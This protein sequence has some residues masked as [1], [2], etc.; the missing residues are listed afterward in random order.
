MKIRNKIILYFSSTTIV[1]CAIT[2]FVIYQLVAAYRENLFQDQLKDKIVFSLKFLEEVQ[3]SSI[4]LLTNLDQ[5]TINDLYEEKL[6]LFDSNKKLIY[7]SLDDTKILKAESILK[8]LNADKKWIETKEGDFDVIGVRVEIKGNEFYGI[9]KAYDTFGHL[10]LNYLKYT[11]LGTFIVI[12]L[13]TLLISSYLSQ[14]IF[15]PIYRMTME[16]EAIDLNNKNAT[17][18]IENETDEFGFLAQKFNELIQKLQQAFT[19]QK[20]TIHHI[21]HELKTP[22]AILVSNLE[23]MEKE[24]DISTLQTLITAQ[25]ENTLSLGGIINTLLE[26]SKIESGTEMPFE[27]LRIDELLMDVA[28]EIQKLYSDFSM[29]VSFENSIVNESDLRIKG[30]LKLLTIGIQNMISNSIKY[31]SNQKAE[32]SIGG[33][34][35]EIKIIFKNEGDILKEEER[36]F[37]FG[38]FF[39]GANSG[40]QHGFGLGLVMVQKILDLHQGSLIY[41]SEQENI[42]IFEWRLP[43]SSS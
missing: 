39:R 24:K 5:I 8:D 12:V 36:D 17:L 11:L 31:S 4:D 18:S 2:F 32:F 1:L 41:R 25:K 23:A 15:K 30:N 42:N 35:N 10:Q 3:Q 27:E 40:G 33:T 34:A 20:H 9:Y 19:F 14:Q 6:L 13:L 21:S 28:S 26:I 37:L 43:K 7:A 22:I 29:T 16:L 38:Y